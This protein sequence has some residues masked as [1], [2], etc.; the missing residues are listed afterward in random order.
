MASEDRWK[1]T[2]DAEFN[3]GYSATNMPNPD[4]RTAIAAEYSAYQLFKI[5]TA[6]EGI[7]ASL[8]LI[9]SKK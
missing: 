9:A 6:L 4:G 5:R 8:A 2:M 1:T 7:N 3:P